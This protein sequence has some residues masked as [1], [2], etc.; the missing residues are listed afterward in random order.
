MATLIAHTNRV[1]T[2]LRI[3]PYRFH[4]VAYDLTEPPHIHVVGPDGEVKF[5]LDPVELDV[6][7]RTSIRTRD[8]REIERLVRE[9]QAQLLESWH[10]FKNQ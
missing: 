4:F 2:V 5:W 3:G 10:A 6:T 1:P 8:V 7:R 9:N